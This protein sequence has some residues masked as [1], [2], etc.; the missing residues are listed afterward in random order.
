[1]LGKRR[2]RRRRW[3]RP[4]RDRASRHRRG[5]LRHRAPS[6]TSR[7]RARPRTRTSASAGVAWSSQGSRKSASSPDRSP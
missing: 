4:R 2:G 7:R 3:A 5:P 6:R 1:L